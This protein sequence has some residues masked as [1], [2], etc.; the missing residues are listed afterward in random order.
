MIDKQEF[1]DWGAEKVA[2]DPAFARVLAH[3]TPSRESSSALF[4]I[5]S[6]TQS[7]IRSSSTVG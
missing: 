2:G 6:T 1:L 5:I 4:W 3:I 7:A